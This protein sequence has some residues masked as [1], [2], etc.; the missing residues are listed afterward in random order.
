MTKDHEEFEKFLSR[1]YPDRSS[2]EAAYKKMRFKV[3]RYFSF[4]RCFDPE[5][6]ADETIRRLSDNLL[7]EGAESIEKPSSYLYAVARNVYREDVRDNIRRER[8]L[9]ALEELWLT[10]FGDH[11]D[12]RRWC[13]QQLAPEKAKLIIQYY[14]DE[15]ER[16]ELIQSRG[17]SL[18][19]LRVQ[20][21]RIKAELR[22]CNEECL[23]RKRDAK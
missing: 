18:G 2:I 5:N 4:K 9:K 21:H 8:M 16:T 23:E 12:C 17:R 13:L 14:L 19:W 3:V 20:I 15:E 22:S 1:L 6:L 11:E 10:T 7:Q